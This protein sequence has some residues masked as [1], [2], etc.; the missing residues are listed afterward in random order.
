MTDPLYEGSSEL[1]QQIRV[2]LQ[3]IYLLVDKCIPNL[4]PAQTK[5]MENRLEAS[6]DECR[7]F[8]K[9]G[10]KE[11]VLYELRDVGN[12]LVQFISDAEKKFWKD[13]DNP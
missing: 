6:L 8:Q 3:A 7:F 10:N 1:D 5:V 2:S 4:T 9:K 13:Q 11:R 12:W